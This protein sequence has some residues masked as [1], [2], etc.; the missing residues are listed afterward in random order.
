[1]EKS[2]EGAKLQYDDFLSLICKQNRDKFLQFKWKEGRLDKFLGVYLNRNEKY[3]NFGYICKV[4]FVLS[5]GQSSIERGFSVNKDLL[6]E[7]LG[8]K[9]TYSFLLGLAE[10]HT[11]EYQ[12]RAKKNNH[13]LSVV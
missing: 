11:H 12:Y 5:H 9:P 2:A 1:M 4:I 3:Q 7:N 13:T 10:F 8:C 6:V